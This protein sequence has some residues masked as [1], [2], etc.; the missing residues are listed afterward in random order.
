[1]LAYKCNRCGK[2]YDD[3]SHCRE[4][5]YSIYDQTTKLPCKRMDLCKSCTY[6]LEDFISICIEKAVVFIGKDT[7]GE[8]SQN[9]QC[10]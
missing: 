10:I 1:M 3:N 9:K 7:G 2:Y 5:K 6:L 4:A 8:N